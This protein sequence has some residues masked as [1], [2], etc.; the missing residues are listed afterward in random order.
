MK[1]EQWINENN[2]QFRQHNVRPWGTYDLLVSTDGGVSWAQMPRS[3]GS[4][5]SEISAFEMV[6]TENKTNGKFRSELV[7]W[8]GQERADALLKLFEEE[9]PSVDY[10]SSNDSQQ[11]DKLST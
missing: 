7:N 10:L 9:I 2:V 5:I 4:R 6:L 11:T 3:F 1:L 8:M